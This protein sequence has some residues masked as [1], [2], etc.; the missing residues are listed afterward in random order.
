MSLRSV[1]IL[2]VA[3]LLAGASTAKASTLLGSP[4]SAATPDAWACAACP[5]EGAPLGFRQFALRDATV[6]T[7]EDGLVTSVGVHAKRMG[8]SEDPYVAVLRPGDDGVST[9]VVA[10][11]A[12]PVSAS[13]GAHVQI[14]NLRLPIRRGDAIAFVFRPGEVDLGIR[15]RP[16]PDGAVQSFQTP[17]DPC[18]M[19]GGTGIE[20]L[21]DA[22]VEPD[23]DGD[24]MG[25]ETQDPDG[26]GLGMDWQE[27]WFE[28]FEAGDE[29]DEDDAVGTRA[30]RLPKDLRLVNA[31]RRTLL[32][33]APKPGRISASITVPANRRS[34][35]G[36]FT[37][38]LTGETRVRRPGRV[39][40]KLKPTPAGKRLLSKRK[41]V[42]TKTVVAYFPRESSLTLLMRSARL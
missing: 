42:R 2:A 13:E 7:P 35:A 20:L 21:L 39:R 5:A 36:P 9:T 32:L 1:P 30:R 8:G 22:F 26:G 3:S 31:D 33:T 17:C 23:V 11:A 19:D 41:R 40:L 29:L 28:D 38:I 18:G 37:T 34:G 24:G 14:D 25:D 12:V 15:D 6:E 10:T 27:D 4:D 16:R